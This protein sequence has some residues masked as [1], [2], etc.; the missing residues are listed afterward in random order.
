M[1][2]IVDKKKGY[3]KLSMI[4]C[5]NVDEE[6]LEKF[7]YCGKDIREKL[8]VLSFSSPALNRVNVDTN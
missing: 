6:A 1:E 7:L 3:W 5:N 2:V 4:D 8:P